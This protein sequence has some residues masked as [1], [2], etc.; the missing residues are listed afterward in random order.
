M[1][2]FLHDDVLCLYDLIFSFPQHH[3]LGVIMALHVSVG[4]VGRAGAGAGNWDILKTD[5]RGGKLIPFLSLLDPAWLDTDVE[6]W[7]GWT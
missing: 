3:H 7:L 4:D 5:T 1:F 2:Y 6:T